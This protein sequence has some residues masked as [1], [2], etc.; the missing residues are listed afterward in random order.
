MRI[1]FAIITNIAFVILFMALYTFIGF[2]AGFAS[3]HADEWYVGLLF[4]ACVALHVVTFTLM[5]KKHSRISYVI[6]LIAAIVTYAAIFYNYAT[7][8][9]GRLP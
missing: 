7:M 6:G 1:L 2:S 9:S 3:N 4:F 8:P 5:W